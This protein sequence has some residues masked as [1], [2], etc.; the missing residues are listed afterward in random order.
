[1]FRRYYDWNVFQN[2]R[3]TI[4]VFSFCLFFTKEI[5]IITNFS[6]VLDY[7]YKA[8]PTQRVPTRLLLP[9]IDEII[10]LKR[11]LAVL[12]PAWPL[13]VAYFTILILGPSDRIIKN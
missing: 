8:S 4:N 12:S 5:R 10:H 13:A 3:H 9:G 2:Q 6:F 7:S 11:H 1:M